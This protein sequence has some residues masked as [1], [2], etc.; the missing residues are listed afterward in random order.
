[1]TSAV[2]MASR[3]A[4]MW[5]RAYT[6]GLQSQVGQVRRDE[7]ASD[8]FEHASADRE[9]GR[10]SS[11]TAV[12]ILARV[13]MGIP[14]DLVWRIEQTEL[15][16]PRWP[17]RAAMAVLHR[18]AVAGDWVLRRGLPAYTQLI[19]GIYALIGALVIVTAPVNNGDASVAGLVLFGLICLTMSALMFSGYRQAPSRVRLGPVMVIG[20]AGFMGV[21]LWASVVAP[22]S[23]I[24]VAW[25][26]IRRARGSITA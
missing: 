22:L 14:A 7:L 3:A 23:V 19:A 13:V 16:A 26:V 5:G 17:V 4:A 2:R 18:L 8:H 6:V 10:R 21:V 11:A 25:T 24:P 20:S 9:A 12:S 15:H 1:M